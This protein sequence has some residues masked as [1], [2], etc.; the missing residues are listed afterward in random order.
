MLLRLTTSQ[1]KNRQLLLKG[2]PF[3]GFCFFDMHASGAGLA[4]LSEFKT[5]EH[6]EHFPY[7]WTDVFT[8][9]DFKYKIMVRLNW[10]QLEHSLFSFFPWIITCTALV[11]LLAFLKWAQSS[12]FN[13]IMVHSGF[14]LCNHTPAP[15]QTLHRSMGWWFL[16]SHFEGQQENKWPLEVAKSRQ[17]SVNEWLCY[18]F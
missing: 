7:S 18:Y 2:W 17:S 8:I 3:F 6:W 4:H 1:R 12:C 9:M 13:P 16:T 5:F 15:A 11:T 14:L 10:E